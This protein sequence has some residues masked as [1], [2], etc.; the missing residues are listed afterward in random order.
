ML[1]CVGSDTK[2]RTKSV[3]Q[4]FSVIVYA[5]LFAEFYGNAVKVSFLFKVVLFMKSYGIFVFV[6]HDGNDIRDFSFFGFRFDGGMQRASHVFVQI[7]FVDIYGKIRSVPIRASR[8][9]NVQKRSRSRRA[10]R[11]RQRETDSL[12]ATC[13]GFFL[14]ILRRKGAFLPAKCMC[15]ARIRHRFSRNERHP[16]PVRF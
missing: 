7:I 6:G 5:H 8:I 16:L 4:R 9:V 11:F 2:C 15:F 12:F 14:R 1:V 10:Y 13:R 3:L